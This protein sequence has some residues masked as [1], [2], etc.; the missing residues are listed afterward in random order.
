MI[1]QENPD[2]TALTI[3]SY[4]TR[5][6]FP[7]HRQHMTGRCWCLNSKGEVPTWS[8]W[9]HWILINIVHILMH[10]QHVSHGFYLCN[11]KNIAKKPNSFLM[12]SCLGSLLWLVPFRTH[13]QPGD[14]E[15][16]EVC[17]VCEVYGLFYS[18]SL[19]DLPC[20]TM[21]FWFKHDL[22]SIHQALLILANTL[23]NT[24]PHLA[25]CQGL[26]HCMPWWM[27]R[28]MPWQLRAEE[29]AW[30]PPWGGPMR[31]ASAAHKWSSDLGR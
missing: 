1:F 13:W 6:L 22:P 27:D 18:R 3:S 19:V 5:C 28:S 15:V 20:F 7:R 23:C 30:R 12:F 2:L 4:A 29:R 25:M 21:F 11:A 26:S 31:R 17:E 9:I 24:L 14:G 8:T 10:D 16:C